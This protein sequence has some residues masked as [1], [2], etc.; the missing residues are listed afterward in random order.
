[1]SG[2]KFGVSD[3]I[4]TGTLLGGWRVQYEGLRVV[5]RL[6]LVFWRVDGT[7]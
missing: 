4:M 1:V 7:A 6:E 3:K 5:C 2:F